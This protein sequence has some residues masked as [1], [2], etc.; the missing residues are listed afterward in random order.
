MLAVLSQ[1]AAAGSHLLLLTR[2]RSSTSSEH[3]RPPP[4]QVGN[5]RN[6]TTAGNPTTGGPSVWTTI[7]NDP[8]IQKSSARKTYVLDAKHVGADALGSATAA[9][10]AASALARDRGDTAY[11]N[12]LLAKAESLFSFAIS[13]PGEEKSYCKAL[14]QKMDAD[15]NEDPKGTLQSLCSFKVKHTAD[16][17]VQKMSASALAEEERVR[18]WVP[19]YSRSTCMAKLDFSKCKEAA[20]YGHV[21]KR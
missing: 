18:C 19:E 11:A 6:Y 13:K 5:P 8:G 21:Y 17:L 20:K 12:A 14:E 10:A 1:Q 3:L 9:L 2:M 4:L 7:A 15:G 16:V